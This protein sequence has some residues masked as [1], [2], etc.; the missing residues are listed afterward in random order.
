[1]IEA[2]S[3]VLSNFLIVCPWPPKLVILEVLLVKVVGMS[4]QA[5]F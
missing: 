4:E 2:V 3:Y 1:M 5:S